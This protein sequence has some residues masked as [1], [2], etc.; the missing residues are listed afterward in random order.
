MRK[1]G[2]APLRFYCF[3]TKEIGVLGVLGI[4]CV[5]AGAVAFNAMNGVRDASAADESMGK[6]GIQCLH[7]IER[8]MMT[9]DGAENALLAT[10]IDEK[11]RQS[12][13]S[14]F[15]AAQRSLDESLKAYEGLPLFA[16]ESR[17]WKD[18][19]RALERWSKDHERFVQLAGEHGRNEITQTYK[20][21]S[22][23]AL[24][25]NPVSLSAAMSLL[26]AL[27]EADLGGSD[28]NSEISETAP[29]LYQEYIVG[30]VALGGSI[31]AVGIIVLLFN[32]VR[33]PQRR[34]P[35]GGR[36]L[37]LDVEAFGKVFSSERSS[38][39]N[40]GCQ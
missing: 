36:R 30:A 33:R 23:Q 39:N 29:S 35:M 24:E 37:T 10:D 38:K 5:L 20:S 9:V 6:Q 12:I 27:I 32:R 16:E 28:E 18:F 15:D 8:A 7:A 4:F 17:L 19:L 11:K 34:F 2:P 13:Y 1:A 21:M 26:D 14:Q 31:L 25:V 22:A 3:L 40:E